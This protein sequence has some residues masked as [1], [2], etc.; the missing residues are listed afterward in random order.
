MASPGLP[1]RYWKRSPASNCRHMNPVLFGLFSEKPT[2]G[3]K[4]QIG[5]QVRRCAQ[6]LVELI[7]ATSF[8]RLKD[9]VT[10]TCLSSVE[11]TPASLNIRFKRIILNGV[12]HLIR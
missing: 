9:S 3:E 5:F 7:D 6:G 8:G 4:S 11:M 2:A 12:C 1:T 10:R